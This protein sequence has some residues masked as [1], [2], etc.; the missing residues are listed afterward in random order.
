MIFSLIKKN[1]LKEG[2]RIRYLWTMIFCRI[3]DHSRWKK[4]KIV[5]HLSWELGRNTSIIH[6]SKRTRLKMWLIIT[7]ASEVSW[8]RMGRFFHDKWWIQEKCVTKVWMNFWRYQ[9]QEVWAFGL[10]FRVWW[11]SR[12]ICRLIEGAVSWMLLWMNL[13][14]RVFAEN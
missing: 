8:R 4:C 7:Q 3:N 2:Y 13:F 1:K 5:L 12:R 14:W 6:R 9:N 11:I 10:D